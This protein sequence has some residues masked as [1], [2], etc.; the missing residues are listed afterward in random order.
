MNVLVPFVLATALLGAGCASNS[1]R[2][3]AYQSH[4]ADTIRIEK[5][6]YDASF[7]R[8]VRLPGKVIVI[9]IKDQYGVVH[10]HGEVARRQGF[11]LHNHIASGSEGFETPLTNPE[12]G[13]H[14][15][16]Y[17]EARYYS[18]T[19][20]RPHG[21]APMPHTMFFNHREGLALH[22]GETYRPKAMRGRPLGMSHG[23]VR[24]P[25]RMAEIIFTNFYDA[26]MRV[27]IT[28]DAETLRRD[29]E[30]GY[31]MRTARN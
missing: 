6:G 11:E 15:I 31:F 5:Y 29:W 3:Y 13:P 12:H 8:Q 17:A 25:L 28:W 22:G 9:F 18:K 14:R 27:I 30:H 7:P 26:R 1:A 4:V 24:L 10:E 20:P 2:H 16:E 21:G 23:C 19:Y